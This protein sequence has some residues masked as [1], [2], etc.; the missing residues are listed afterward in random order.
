M[1]KRKCNVVIC[2]NI[3]VNAVSGGARKFFSHAGSRSEIEL[4]ASP[5]D[6]DEVSIVAVFLEDLLQLTRK[7]LRDFSVFPE[8]G[9]QQVEMSDMF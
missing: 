2:D 3:A 4:K 5:M 6:K 1:Y 9:R 7:N 8:L